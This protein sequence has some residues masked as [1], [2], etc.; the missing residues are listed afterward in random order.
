[1]SVSLLLF[2]STVWAEYGL[3]FPE[4]ATPGAREIY[5]VHMLTTTISAVLTVAIFA[6]VL[7]AV[8]RFRKSKGY[9]PDQKFH[10]TWF[11]RWAWLLV[12]GLVLGVDLTIANSAQSVL[13]K[14][15]VVPDEKMMDVKVVGHQWW[16]EYE[17]LDH[18][19]R[20]ESRYLDRETAGEQLYLRAVDN[21][22]VLP[23]NT[24]IRFLQTSADVLHAFWVPELGF[25]KDSIPGYI[26]ETWAEIDREG[27]FRGQCAELCGTWHSRMPIV[28]E[29][30]SPEKFEQ[31]VAEQKVAMALKE[32]EAA[33]D[34]TWS[35]EDLMEK[36]RG[37][38][39]SNC[40][41]CH[42]VTGLGLP[43]A[44][45]ALKDSPIVK[46]PL[47]AH[48]DIV[49]NGKQGSAMPAWAQLNNL[50]LAAIITYERNA[51]DNNTGDVV[52]P[53]D[54]GAAR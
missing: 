30:V 43:P 11:G 53:R 13:E 47:A 35:K 34:K 17:Y 31:W 41:T 9:V 20:I 42:Q 27:T 12:P 18:D 46:G 16:W 7:F 33:S 40:G 5:D 22:L 49:M 19:V 26:T 48:L 29:A 2:S 28:V 1:L 38:Y 36:G 45:P 8:F 15:W 52:Q 37:L 10:Q 44:F 4:P 39:N 21:V 54:I 50:D 3:N 51:W 14:L 24:R 23:T 25:K 6:I 32:A